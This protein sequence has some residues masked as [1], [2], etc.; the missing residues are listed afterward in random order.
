MAI[1]IGRPTM[2]IFICGISFAQIPKAV[3][4]KRSAAIAG[5]A[6]LIARTNRFDEIDMTCSK[7]W[8]FSVIIPMLIILKLS[9]RAEIRAW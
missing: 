3:L 6:I 9:K 4:V 2:R 1:L 5:D 7:R 8:L